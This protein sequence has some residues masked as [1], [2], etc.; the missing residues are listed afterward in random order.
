MGDTLELVV[1]NQL[2]TDILE[3]DWAPDGSILAGGDGTNAAFVAPPDDQGFSVQITNQ[4]DCTIT[5]NSLVTVS[6]LLPPLFVT[7]DPDTVISGGN[8]QLQATLDPDYQ[9]SWIPDPTL[10]ATN[11]S[12]PIATPDSTTTYVVSIT[13]DLGCTNTR[14][15]TVV[16]LDPR[17]IEP[18]VFIPSGF[19]PN[20]DGKNDVFQIRGS[21]IDELYLIIYNRWGEKVFETTDPQGAWDGTFRDEQLPPDVYGYYARILCLGGE[22]YVRKGNITLIK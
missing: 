4:Y 5:L 12:N 19:S 13:D 7:A 1:D 8:S 17:C 9:Y 21:Y 11:I 3:Y 10:S 14:T 2:P 18:F 20:G 6:E 16:V 15:V 22:E